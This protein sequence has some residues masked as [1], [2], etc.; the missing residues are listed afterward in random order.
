MQRREK[1]YLWII[2]FCFGYCALL[3]AS[4][5]LFGTVVFYGVFFACCAAVIVACYYGYKFI[6]WV[7]K[8]RFQRAADLAK[9]AD[10]LE[11]QREAR[12]STDRYHPGSL[13]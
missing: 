2:A 3:L 9:V 5:E 11:E 1:A 10:L 13:D 12:R 8:G 7:D 6:Y 4:P